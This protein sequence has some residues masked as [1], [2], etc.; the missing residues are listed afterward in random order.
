MHHYSFRV[1]RSKYSRQFYFLLLYVLTSLFT[2]NDMVLNLDVGILTPVLY[3]SIYYGLGSVLIGYA[4]TQ[5]CGT[6]NICRKLYCYAEADVSTKLSEEYPLASHTITLAKSITSAGSSIP[7][8]V[9][10]S[11]RIKNIV[12][13]SYRTLFFWR[14]EQKWQLILL[15]PYRMTFAI[16]YGLS[17]ASIT[18]TITHSLIHFWK[19]IKIYFGRSL[20]EQP[21]IHAQLMSRYAQ[22]IAQSCPN[23]NN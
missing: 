21:D 18:S 3:V 13:Y 1:G 12:L 14:R 23:N 17:F 20:R 5:T 6:V 10:M 11:T 19:P 15:S 7:T 16:S 9:S 8:R 22:G 4:S 2:G